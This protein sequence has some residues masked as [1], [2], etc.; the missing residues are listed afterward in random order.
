M[1]KPKHTAGPWKV[2]KDSNGN[3]CVEFGKMLDCEK[4]PN[5]KLVA[6]AP[7]LLALCKEVLEAVDLVGQNRKELK[8]ALKSVISRVEK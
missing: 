2:S 5:A 3:P 8:K 7:E 6:A 4:L 1:N